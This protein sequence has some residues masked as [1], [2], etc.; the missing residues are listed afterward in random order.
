MRNVTV[1]I[2]NE[3][4]LHARP[5][6]LF[7]NEAKRYSCDVKIK[8]NDKEINGKS[9]LELLALGVCRGKQINIITNGIDEDKASQGLVDL[10]KHMEE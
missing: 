4:G 5:A 8:Y 9:I 6:K 1:Q 2:E 3:Q 10:L 7:V